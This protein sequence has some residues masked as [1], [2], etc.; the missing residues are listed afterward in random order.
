MPISKK[1]SASA[2][3]IDTEVA[4]TVANGDVSAGADDI[5]Q[6]L[7]GVRMYNLLAAIYLAIF[8]IGLDAAIVSTVGVLSLLLEKF[9][10]IITLD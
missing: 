4:L 1:N 6:Y 9:L 8:L 5:H 10:R 7:T 3:P 2:S